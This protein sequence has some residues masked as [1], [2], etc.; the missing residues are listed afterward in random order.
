MIYIFLK[1]FDKLISRNI[2]V[3]I[4]SDIYLN[5]REE[6]VNWLNRLT[7]SN[8]LGSIFIIN[9][10]HTSS[11]KYN[12]TTN[13]NCILFTQLDDKKINNLRYSFEENINKSKTTSFVCILSK[14]EDICAELQSLGINALNISWNGGPS[15]QKKIPKIL[16]SLDILLQ[17][18]K[19]TGSSAFVCSESASHKLECS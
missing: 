14:G 2:S 17:Q 11:I 19:S 18:S 10:V 16:C 7:S 5:T 13:Y 15:Q 4:E 3:T 9:Q 1:R 8:I 6:S 12:T